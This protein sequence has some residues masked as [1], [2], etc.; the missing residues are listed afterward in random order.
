MVPCSRVFGTYLIYLVLLCDVPLNLYDL[1]C[2]YEHQN[3]LWTYFSVKSY[4]IC[5]KKGNVRLQ[6]NNYQIIMTKFYLMQF[7]HWRR[8]V[9]F[10]NIANVWLWQKFKFV[11][12]KEDFCMKMQCFVPKACVNT[13]YRF[14]VHTPDSRTGLWQCPLIYD[15]ACIR[16]IWLL[17]RI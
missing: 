17:P 14:Y 7:W 5:K 3:I 12:E 4:E 8:T 9:I 10:E 6:W 11:N 1:A 2:L 15:P 16:S 13:K